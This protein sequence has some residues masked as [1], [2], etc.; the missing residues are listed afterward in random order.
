MSLARSGDEEGNET[1]HLRTMREAD[2]SFPFHQETP[3]LRKVHKNRQN[4]VGIILWILLD[5]S[6]DAR[7][8]KK[9]ILYGAL[10]EYDQLVRGSD[11]LIRIALDQDEISDAT[12]S[13]FLKVLD[14]MIGPAAVKAQQALDQA[15]R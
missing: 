8:M 15:N 2:Q 1:L 12:R 7:G 3:D 10:S 5:P 6:M 13:R 4:S 14:S 11:N 9:A